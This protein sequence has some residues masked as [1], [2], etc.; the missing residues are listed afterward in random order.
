MVFIVEYIE[1]LW[2]A[3]T[4]GFHYTQ[5]P[6]PR[7]MMLIRPWPK[8][9][10]VVINHLGTGFLRRLQLVPKKGGARF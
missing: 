10:V 7:N 8:R 9:L 3:I 4:P 2:R 1:D 6:N 5:P